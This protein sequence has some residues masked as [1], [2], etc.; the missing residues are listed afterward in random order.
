MFFPRPQTSF[1]TGLPVTPLW[2]RL[3]VTDPLAIDLVAVKNFLNI[4]LEDSYFDDEKRQMIG[5]AQAVVE[6]YCQITLVESTWVGVL[7]AFSDVIRITKR[8]FI[9]V[10]RIDYVAADTG[11]ITTLP[12]ASY[13]SGPMHQLCGYVARADG[14]AWPDVA[15]R[16]DAVR[17]HIKAGY[18]ELPYDLMQAIMVTVASIDRSRADDGGRDKTNT[19]YGI[20]HQ[21]AASIM[22]PE[23][24]ALLAPY[25]YLTL[26]VA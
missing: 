21:T 20:E 1:S 22:P 17:V 23:A 10:D 15:R 14:V 4:P 7:P 9:T 26:G 5:T 19:I 16:T 12:A 8:P 2:T 3:G 25:R 6:Q 18:E 11:E 24:K 13:G